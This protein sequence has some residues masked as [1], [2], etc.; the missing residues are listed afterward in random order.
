MPIGIPP[1]FVA[2]CV[3]VYVIFGLGYLIRERLERRR[4]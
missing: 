4:N 1:E 3:A 2:A